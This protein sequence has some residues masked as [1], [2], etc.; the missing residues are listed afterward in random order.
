MSVHSVFEARNSLSRLIAE[1]VAGGD[2]V[3]ANRGRPVVRLVPVSDGEEQCTGK[4]FAQ[5]LEANPLPER[6][7]RSPEE[8]DVQIAESRDAWE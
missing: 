3:I 7:L 1:S 5:W 8:L 4:S 6:L 2:V